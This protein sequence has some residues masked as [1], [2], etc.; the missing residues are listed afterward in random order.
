MEASTGMMLRRT[1]GSIEPVAFGD[2]WGDSTVRKIDVTLGNEIVSLEAAAPLPNFLQRAVTSF[3]RQLSEVCLIR[4]AGYSEPVFPLPSL[5]DSDGVVDTDTLFEDSDGSHRQRQACFLLLNA[6]KT[7][8]RHVIVF[9]EPCVGEA[10]ELFQVK[11][12]T[13]VGAINALLS[14]VG[15][16]W[17]VC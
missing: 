15:R 12:V 4:L 14:K 6:G 1:D 3:H 11:E 17:L 16:E 10:P 8:A 9:E 7:F 13:V 5:V 2:Q